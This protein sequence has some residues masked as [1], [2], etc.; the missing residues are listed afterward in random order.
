MTAR[1]RASPAPIWRAG[2]A[3]EAAPDAQTALA[4][5]ERARPDLVLVDP[6]IP[7]ARGWEVCRRVQAASA[8][9]LIVLTAFGGPVEKA[10]ALEL[11]AEDDAV[12]P[13]L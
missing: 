13:R 11:G 6:T 8:A 7:G 5:L 12:A 2:F 10:V 3:V 9:P 4:T 1:R